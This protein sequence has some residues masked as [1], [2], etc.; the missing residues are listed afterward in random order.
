MIICICNKL[1]SDRGWLEA[2]HTWRTAAP[3]HKER[4]GQAGPGKAL[5]K[6]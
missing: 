1:P 4:K 2:H 3:R 5:G 6:A